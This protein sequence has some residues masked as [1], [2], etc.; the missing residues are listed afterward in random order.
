MKLL[1]VKRCKSLRQFTPN[2][3]VWYCTM[4]EWKPGMKRHI[5]AY[6]TSDVRRL[7][8]EEVKS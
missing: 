3:L 6:R 7:P 1:S 4:P 8:P 5:H 2:G